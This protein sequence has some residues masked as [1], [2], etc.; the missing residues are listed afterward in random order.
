MMSPAMPGRDDDA[1]Q[2]GRRFGDYVA[3]ERLGAG[4]MA[5]VYLAAR[6]QDRDVE[7]AAV[8]RLLPHL[9]WDLEFL[10]MFLAEAELAS[11]LHHPN[12]ARVYDF[13]T[14][15]GGHY[16]V[17]EYV[18][19]AT[20]RDVLKTLDTQ[21]V[22][23]DFGVGVVAELATALHYAHEW[24]APD[25]SVTG[26]VHRD[27]S[28]SNV[29]LASDGRMKLLDFGIARIHGRTQHTRAGTIKGKI[30]YMSPEQC[31][32][33]AVDRRSDVFGLGI[34][35]YELCVQERAFFADNDYGFIGRILSGDYAAPAEIDP[36]FPP[37]LA[38]IIDSCLAVE[39]GERY[40]DAASLET[41]LRSF[42]AEHQLELGQEHRAE[43]LQGLLGEMPLP[44]IDRSTIKRVTVR[45]ERQT[46]WWPWVPVSLAIGGL[47]VLVGVSVASSSPTSTPGVI[48]S[49]VSVS[50]GPGPGVAD[51]PPAVRAQVKVP[52][53][54][55]P[56]PNT[57][58]ELSAPA[59][60]PSSP[61]TVAESPESPDPD[62]PRRDEKRRRKSGRAD[63]T[64]SS[65]RKAVSIDAKALLPPSVR[66]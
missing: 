48:D 65:D 41:A 29:M 9:A 39:P 15:Q 11:G 25:G 8:K 53:A 24:V 19:G 49:D 27:V 14:A 45:E 50:P 21:R 1:P 31:R 35:L 51:S 63:D 57:A 18:H 52:A 59:Q 23:L 58:P 13:G 66:E 62:P 7:L 54:A 38:A 61:P 20:L 22:P 12:I 4:G 5:E 40:P 44:A 3:V 26:I 56:Q 42:A 43:V 10:R 34:L 32:G 55:D 6:P 46:R 33:D 47:G 17:M 16:L 36:E 60:L 30:G 64:A 28:P 37:E 2:I